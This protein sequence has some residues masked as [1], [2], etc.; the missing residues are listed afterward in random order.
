MDA[1]ERLGGGAVEVFRR[2]AFGRV[3]DLADRWS[4]LINGR[5]PWVKLVAC[6]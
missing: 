4:V 1:A 5:E 6:D 2:E 3:L